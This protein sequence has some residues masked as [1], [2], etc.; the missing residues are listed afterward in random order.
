MSFRTL[1]FAFQRDIWNTHTQIFHTGFEGS[2]DQF[3]TFSTVA[4]HAVVSYMFTHLVGME[5]KSFQ[6]PWDLLHQ[7][8]S[9]TPRPYARLAL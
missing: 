4:L 2:G 9:P 3:M 7:S 1:L 8:D 5:Q 6:F